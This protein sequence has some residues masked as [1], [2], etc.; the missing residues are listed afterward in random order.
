MI[1][2]SYCFATQAPALTEGRAK[3]V[4]EKGGERFKV[5]TADGNH[6]DAMFFDRRGQSGKGKV[7]YSKIESK[8]DSSTVL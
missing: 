5:A 8:S 4:H 2:H 3:L 6:I 1:I 7:E